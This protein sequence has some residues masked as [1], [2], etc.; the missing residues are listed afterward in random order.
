M[1]DV[2]HGNITISKEELK[3]LL[4]RI[5]PYQLHYGFTPQNPFLISELFPGQ[6]NWIW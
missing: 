2:K 3:K 5:N 1:K 6:H 4:K